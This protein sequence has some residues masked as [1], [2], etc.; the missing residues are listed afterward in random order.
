MASVGIL[1]FL[2]FFYLE[3]KNDDFINSSTVITKNIKENNV[4][5]RLSSP[6]LSIRNRLN[7]C[8]NIARLLRFFVGYSNGKKY[9]YG[10]DVKS[11]FP[12]A[13]L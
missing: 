6:T 5:K 2:E 11:G 1:L 8:D 4:G 3:S 13:I 7:L 10:R 9:L 12:A